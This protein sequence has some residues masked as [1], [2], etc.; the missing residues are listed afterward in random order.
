MSSKVS[1]DITWYSEYTQSCEF[2]DRVSHYLHLSMNMG[3][4]G[5]SVKL[6]FVRRKN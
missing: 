3:S 4:S 5:W 1:E 6:T 2:D